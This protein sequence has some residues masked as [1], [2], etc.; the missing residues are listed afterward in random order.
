METRKK[1]IVFASNS[2]SAK[3]GFG[4]YIRE[5]MTHLYKTGKYELV[6]YAAGSPWEAP[7]AARWP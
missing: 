1:K 7:D 6:L 4:G 2:A 3:T 5:I